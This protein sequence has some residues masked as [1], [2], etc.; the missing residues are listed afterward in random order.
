[1]SLWRYL[2]RIIYYHPA[3]GEDDF[4]STLYKNLETWFKVLGWCIVIATL[5]YGYVKTH[6]P[7]FR[8]PEVVL[9]VFLMMLVYTYFMRFTIILRNLKTVV[10]TAGRPKLFHWPSLIAVV[11]LMFVASVLIHNWVEAVVALQAK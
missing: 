6:S 3:D 5:H 2:P 8:V 4:C 10:F 7:W 1:M 11:L 9:S